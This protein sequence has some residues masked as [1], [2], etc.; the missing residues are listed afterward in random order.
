MYCRC[1][2]QVAL[3]FLSASANFNCDVIITS[4]SH[5]A[6]CLA[7]PVPPLNQ[8][9]RL[10]DLELELKEP[11]RRRSFHLARPQKIHNV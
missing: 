10:T 7:L 1:R 2:H 5:F 3:S 4:V 11:Q 9:A 6:Q 8:M